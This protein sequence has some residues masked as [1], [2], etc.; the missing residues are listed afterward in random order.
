MEFLWFHPDVPK[1]DMV[2][3]QDKVREHCTRPGALDATALHAAREFTSDTSY[4]RGMAHAARSTR[5]HTRPNNL[6][7]Q[8]MRETQSEGRGR[9]SRGGEMATVNVDLAI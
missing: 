5:Q 4:M 1:E 3:A 8:K 2:A 6:I 7:L 9:K